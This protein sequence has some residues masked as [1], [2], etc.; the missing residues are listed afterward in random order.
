MLQPSPCTHRL[1]CQ[2]AQNEIHFTFEKRHLMYQGLP[3]ATPSERK[4][5]VLATF[6]WDYSGTK[7]E[8]WHVDSPRYSSRAALDVKSRRQA[9]GSVMAPQALKKE[10]VLMRPFLPGTCSKHP[11]YFDLAFLF[12]IAT[13]EQSTQ[14]AVDYT[15]YEHLSGLIRVFLRHTVLSMRVEVSIAAL[16]AFCD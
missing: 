12:A 8:I 7:R 11:R 6:V 14:Q 2:R 16:H 15:P 10:K 3:P 4:L 9:P 13:S 1:H 5:T